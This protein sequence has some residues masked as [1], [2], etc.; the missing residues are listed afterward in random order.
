M[1][2]ENFDIGDKVYR[3]KY[4]NQIFTI[5]EKNTDGPGYF[6]WY[7]L[8]D[9]KEKW[10]TFCIDYKKVFSKDDVLKD[11]EELTYDCFNE[12]NPRECNVFVEISTIRYEYRIFYHKMIDYKTVEFKE[13]TV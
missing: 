12:N 11:G 10:Y 1:K 5:I 7:T 8:T 6:P 3:I 4:P 13:L 2:I 9:G